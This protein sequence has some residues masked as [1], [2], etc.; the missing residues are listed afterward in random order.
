ML[1]TETKEIEDSLIEIELADIGVEVDGYGQVDISSKAQDLEAQGWR[2][3]LM[4]LCPFAFEEEFSADH[5]RFR[6]CI[7]LSFKK[8]QNIH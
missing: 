3:W 1:T 5:V 7:G 8:I 4:T 6:I 2:A